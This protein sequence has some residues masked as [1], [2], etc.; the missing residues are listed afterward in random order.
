MKRLAVLFGAAGFFVASEAAAQTTT[1]CRETFGAVRCTTEPTTS[2]RIML[3]S[4][5][6]ARSLDNQL[7]AAELEA[8][9]GPR[10]E[11]RRCP[12]AGL[13][14][15]RMPLSACVGR[16]V[17]EGRCDDAKKL[18]L[19]NGDFDLAERVVPLCTAAREPD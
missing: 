11:E 1:T 19:R 18:A 15:Q 2:P 16:L 6:R 9:R 4:E 3:P 12:G 10:V 7:K 17:V 14:S 13:F 5:H 8:M